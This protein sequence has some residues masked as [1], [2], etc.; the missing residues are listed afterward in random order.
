[1]Q[2]LGQQV[3]RCWRNN[4]VH[5]SEKHTTKGKATEAYGEDGRWHGTVGG[6]QKQI[7]PQNGIR[8]VDV[9]RNHWRW[10]HWTD[11]YPGSVGLLGGQWFVREQERRWEPVAFIQ[12]RDSGGL[13]QV[14]AVEIVRS[15]QI[16]DVFWRKRQLIDFEKRTSILT[17]LSTKE[18]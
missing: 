14:N 3:Q 2:K 17:F 7:M 13:D 15:A 8:S 10:H 1:M 11:I 5:E 18:I 6:R 12:A 9:E 16:Q 4:E